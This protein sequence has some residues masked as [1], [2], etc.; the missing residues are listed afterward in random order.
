MYGRN[1]GTMM[2]MSKRAVLAAKRAAVALLLATGMISGGM[3]LVAAAPLPASA[4]TPLPGAPNCPMFPADNVWNTNISQLPVDPHSAAWMASMDSST[5]N[6]HPDFGPSGD[7]S[8]PYGIPYT[9]VPPAQALVNVSF[10]YSS[11]SDPGPYPFGASTPIEGGSQST[12][13]RHALMVNPSTCTLY[14]LYDAT[15]SASGSTAGSGAIWNLNSDALRPSGWTSADAAGLPILPG[16]LRYD[17]VQSGSI[18]HAIRMTAENTDDSFI[19]PARHEAG[20]ADNPDLPPM[21][22][23]FRLKA[24][25]NISGYSPQ[26]QVVL[27]AMQQYGLILADNGSNWYFGG[28]ADPAWPSSLVNELKEVPASEFEAVDESSLMIDPNSGQARQNGGAVTCSTNPGY[29]LA[30]A[31]GGVFTFCEPFYGSMGGTKLAAGIVGMASTPDGKGYWLV[32][33]DGGIFSFG[34]A[35]FY[36]SM[37]GHRLNQPIVGMASTPDGNGYWLVA[38]DGGIF[39]FGDAS[40]YGSTGNLR[41]NQPIV[42]MSTTP[43]G[44]GYWLVAADGGIFS[45]GDASFYGS[46]GGHPLNQPIVGMAATSGGGGY[47]LVAK[48]GGIFSFGNAAFYGS[49]GNIELNQPIVG[50]T[51]APGGAGYWMVAADG[52]IFAFGSASFEGSTGSTQLTA[53]IVAMSG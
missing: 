10:Q 1:L 11:E 24:S 3:M 37:G 32:A 45:F 12:G 21:G 29:R 13:D 14:E 15:Y 41:L 23:R 18:T 36:G 38:A 27:R 34:D 46:M 30:A 33:S 47:W 52:G 9:V 7:P 42:G 28:T 51:V 53:P 4:G 50:M 5:T 20:S 19:W 39:S 16:L 35:P 43:D 6:L 25:Y 48:D 26:A 49:A 22:A 44:K 8:N 31:D 17:E 2:E 40:F